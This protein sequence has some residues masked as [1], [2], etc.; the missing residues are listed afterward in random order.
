MLIDLQLHSSYSDGYFR[1]AELAEMIAKLGIK[2]AALTDHNTVGGLP[3]FDAACRK[4]KIKAV[5]GIE[6]YIKLGSQHLNLLWYNFDPLNGDLHELLKESQLR[7]RNQVRR[8]LGRLRKRGFVLNIENILD[9]Y[10]R[11][12]PL[13][14]I[15]DDVVSVPENERRIKRE[16]KTDHLREEVIAAEY[17]LNPDIGVLRESYIRLEEVIALRQRI[18]GQLIINHP[19]KHNHVTK[20]D[21][22]RLKTLGV[23]GLELLSPHHSVNAILYLQHI[24]HEFDFLTTG[25]SDFHRQEHNHGVIKM[26]WDYFTIDSKHLRRIEAV[27]G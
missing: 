9:R 23:D 20:K 1:P 5:P 15:I 25:G 8:L 11:Y 10:S 4:L 7:R 6:L 17:F 14:H 21:W 13:N 16:L 19:A 26:S 2:A 22:Q 24:A 3:E 27:I 12:I 18:G